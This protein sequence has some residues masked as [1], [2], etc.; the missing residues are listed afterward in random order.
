[1]MMAAKHPG[2][3]PRTADALREQ[4]VRSDLRHVV[5]TARPSE[6]D[7]NIPKLLQDLMDRLDEAEKAWKKTR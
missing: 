1:M 3:R 5:K 2:S 4:V 6:T 7:R